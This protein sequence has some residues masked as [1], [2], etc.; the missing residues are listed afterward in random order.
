M[1][2]IKVK[3]NFI[4]ITQTTSTTSVTATPS[5]AKPVFIHITDKNS[6]WTTEFALNCANKLNS[7]V[8]CC[9]YSCYSSD[10]LVHS[11]YVCM[12]MLDIPGQAILFSSSSNGFHII[13][14][15]DGCYC[16][17]QSGCCYCQCYCCYCSHLAISMHFSEQT[18]TRLKNADK[19]M[20][21]YTV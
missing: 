17:V 2:W 5:K 8:C 20:F 6:Y 21:V 10:V 15:D 13:C 11:V 19:R 18:D 4:I 7:S 16:M 14:N 1:A 3:E 12:M 9:C